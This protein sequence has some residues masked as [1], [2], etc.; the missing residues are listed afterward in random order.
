MTKSLGKEWFKLGD[1]FISD[2]IV[3]I[4]NE[5]VNSDVGGGAV[6]V[7]SYTRNH[8]DFEVLYRLRCRHGAFQEYRA[9][10]QGGWRAYPARPLQRNAPER[11]FITV[12]PCYMEGHLMFVLIRKPV[13]DIDRVA[14]PHLRSLVRVEG[15]QTTDQIHCACWKLGQHRVVIPNPSI[16]GSRLGCSCRGVLRQV[17]REL[18]PTR[19]PFSANLRQTPNQVIQRCSQFAQ[20]TYDGDAQSG[21]N[22]TV[23]D[24]FIA[25]SLVSPLRLFLADYSV[26]FGVKEPL[27]FQIEVFDVLPRRP[28]TVMDSWYVVSSSRLYKRP[29]GD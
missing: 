29:C 21:R 5:L 6:I 10:L 1:D 22:L 26:R 12:D 16:K 13:Q 15:L 24:K 3:S 17:D 4:D 2:K 28:E 11:K 25:N 23:H 14:G 27:G 7:E 9:I 19:L 20:T 18:D 8:L